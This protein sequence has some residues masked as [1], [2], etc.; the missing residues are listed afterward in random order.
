MYFVLNTKHVVCYNK[1]ATNSLRVSCFVFFLKR[2]SQTTW[3]PE[4]GWDAASQIETF[5]KLLIECQNR[6]PVVKTV[7]EKAKILG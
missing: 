6:I 7:N 3:Q 1:K 2:V 4:T 5:Q